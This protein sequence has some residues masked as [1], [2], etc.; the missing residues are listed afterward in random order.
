MKITILTLGLLAACAIL[1]A[2]ASAQSSRALSIEKTPGR[3]RLVLPKGAGEALRRYDST[4][5][6]WRERDYPKGVL[7]AY[8]F[9]QTQAPYGVVGDFN[10]DGKADAVLE[11]HT[12]TDWLFVAVL[13]T[14]SGFIVQDIERRSGAYGSASGALQNDMYLGGLQEYL[15]LE[16]AG[17]VESPFEGE[18]LVLRHDAVGVTYVEKGAAVYYLKNKKW[19]VYTTGD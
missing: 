12:G 11:G 2:T 6:A 16:H 13:S 9:T 8:A 5:V 15:E 7:E 14:D 18:P 1:P 19:L 17:K 3:H 10:G 4:F